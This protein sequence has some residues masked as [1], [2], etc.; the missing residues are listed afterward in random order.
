MA[1]P[2]SPQSVSSPD[3]EALL[4]VERSTRGKRWLL[5]EAEERAVLSLMQQ[6]GLSEP[7]ARALTARGVTIDAVPGFLAPRLR[8]QLP[9]PS[10]LTDMDGAVD[11]V[12]QAIRAGEGIAIFGDYDVDGA[13]SAA[14]LLRFLAALGVSPRLYVPDRQREGYGPNAE[15]LK[16]LREEGASL[17]ITVDCGVSAHDALEEAQAVGLDSIVLDHHAAEARLPPAVAV[18]NPNRWDDDSGLGQLA[19]VGVTYLFLVALNRALRSSGWYEQ[20]GHDAPDLLGLLDLVALGTVCDVVPLT[21]LNRAFVAQGLKVLA[22]RRNEGLRALCDVAGVAERPGGYHLGFLLGPR[23][24]A[25]GRIGESHLGATLLS[26]GDPAQCRALAE[27]LDRYNQERRAIEAEVL[28]AAD[29]TSQDAGAPRDLVFAVGQDWHPGVIGIVAGRLKERYDLPTIV[30][31]QDANGLGKG[32]GRSVPGV[33]LGA[34]VIAARQ[35]GLLVNGGGHAMAAGLTVEA[36]KVTALESFLRARIA[37]RL[38]E[39]AY[40]PALSIDACLSLAAAQGSLVEA[41][42]RIAPFGA[43]NPEPRF[44]FAQVKTISADI[45]GSNHVRAIFGDES[46]AR[47]RAIAFRALET[48][49]GERLLARSGRPLHVAGRLRADA[50]RGG[51]AVQ[52]QVDD[53]AES[54]QP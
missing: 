5:R 20:Q 21:G 36:D 30:V 54:G 15:A 12:L 33:D 7:V 42:D 41:L 34:A 47:L 13:T 10:S 14:L 17:V 4:G 29:A 25:G 50:W 38:K 18:V 44:A 49:L 27:R 8:E 31:T 40:R 48:P 43:G 51:D 19:A 23:V 16:L 37:A 46:G 28:A 9:D 53:V 26:E 3:V 22:G 52:L 24:N 1:A 45:V 35:A 2:I 6:H 32:S 39:I 11:R